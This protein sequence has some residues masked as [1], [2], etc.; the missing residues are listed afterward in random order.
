MGGSEEVEAKGVQ[1]AI[2]RWG[3]EVG[4]VLGLWQHRVGSQM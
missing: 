1:G 2:L 3:G 4:E